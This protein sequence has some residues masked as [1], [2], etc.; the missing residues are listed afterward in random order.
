MNQTINWLL[1]DDISIQYLTHKHLLR[2]GPEVTAPLQARV[3]TEGYGARFLAARSANGHWGR[4]FYQPKWTCTH[5]TLLDLKEIGQPPDTPACQEMVVRAFDECMLDSGGVNFAKTMVQSDVA[6]DGMILNYAAYFCPDEKRIENL[7]GY[8]LAQAKPDG[9]YSWDDAAQTG[10]PHTTICVL[11]GFHAYQQAGL[12]RHL[13]A[14]E[15]SENSAIE[16]L[17]SNDLFLSSDKRYLKLSY[18][19]RYRYDLL[20]ALEYFTSEDIPF[21]PRMTPALAWLE[22]KR[23][24]SG[25]WHLE[26]IH[27]GNLHFELEAVGQPSRFITLKALCILDHFRD[28]NI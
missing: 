6:V 11:E 15:N 18:P 25:L 22:G 13:E 4:W 12:T 19:Y 17:L 20:R 28:I 10:D 24:P 14:V 8:I 23:K 7:T 21:D 16:Y 27:K 2:N 26:N 3:A 5:Y 1:S 9:G